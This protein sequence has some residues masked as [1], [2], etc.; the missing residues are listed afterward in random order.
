MNAPIRVLPFDVRPFHRET[1]DSYSTRLL[2][3]NFC[4]DTH[5]TTLTR[6]FETGRTEKNQHD[7]WMRALTTITKRDTL[8]LDPHT[9]AWLKDGFTPCRHFMDTL[10]KRFA[11]THCA[12]GAI[13]EQNPHFDDIVCA[14]HERWI[15][16]WSR[17]NDQ[18]HASPETVHAQAV[19]EKLRRKRLIDV[20]LYLLTTKAIAQDLHPD[21]PIEQAEPLVFPA[22]IRTIQ[23]ITADTFARRFFATTPAFADA[24]AHLD[25]VVSASL[26]N[27]RPA[28]TRALWIYLRPT[29]LALRNAIT[30]DDPFRPDWHHDYPLR[31][32]TARWLTAVTGDLEPIDNYLAIIGDTPITAML[33][34]ADLNALYTGPETTVPR[35]FTC[36]NGHTFDFLPPVTLPGT[37]TPTMYTP[38]CGLCTTRRVR[39]GTNDVQTM[40]THAAAQFDLYRNGGLTAADVANN[41]STKH[42]WTCTKGHSHDVSP[43]KKTLPTYNCALCSNRTTRSGENCMV[44]T[45]P[46]VAAMW[47]QGWAEDCSPATL[48]AGSNLLAK[49]RCTAGHIF[50][51]R[52]W[53][54]VTG[55]RGCNVCGRERTILFEDSLASTHPEVAARLHPTLN[56]YLTAEHVTHGERREMWWLCETNE[57]HPYQ[58][59]IDKVTLGLGC[60]YCCSR[61]LRVGDNDLGTVE[62]VLSL[63]LHP[64]L[65]RKEAHEMFPSDHKLWWKCILNRHDHQ[66]TT[67]NRRQSKGCPKCEPADRILVYRL[68]A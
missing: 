6:A 43:S 7:G 13:V 21:L 29:V 64:Y 59:R 15:G 50:P 49:W 55:K 63:E 19:F 23:A 57:D 51:A 36:E 67:Q 11:C 10:P 31:P 2:A 24:Y 5:R 28:V 41:S 47:A 68:A 37:M 8:H 22:V 60:K 46:S 30:L 42:S 12:H 53:E 25:S 40:S 65:N 16:L 20:R 44:T 27:A 14:R 1:L 58:A 4:D 45:D 54:L 26:G 61:K 33:T 39:P 35:P 52:P 32:S 48:G 18:H 9:S 66:Q 56:G 34:I 17:A 38:D 62:P 3:A